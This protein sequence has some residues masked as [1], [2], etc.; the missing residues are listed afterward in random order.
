[1]IRLVA[2]KH[3]D[4]VAENVSMP[5]EV[6]RGHD[7]QERVVLVGRASWWRKWRWDLVPTGKGP[8]REMLEIP[9]KMPR[10]AIGRGD[11][12]GAVVVGV[13]DPRAM[14]DTSLDAVWF[15]WLLSA[16]IAIERP[17]T[18]RGSYGATP[19]C[20]GRSAAEGVRTRSTGPATNQQ[21]APGVTRSLAAARRCSAWA[22][23]RCLGCFSAAS[24]RFYRDCAITSRVDGERGKNARR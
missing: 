11:V 2:S 4:V 22:D 13:L 17:T 12:P 21:S 16:T 15:V 20:N 8:N 10:T 24:P 3:A 7:A 9:A 19:R 23:R 6:P 18:A 14:F 5:S 1:M